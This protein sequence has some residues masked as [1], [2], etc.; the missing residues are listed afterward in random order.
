MEQRLSLVTLAAEDLAAARRFYEALGWIVA[1]SD[2]K[3]I[4]FFQL[5]GI[6]FSLYRR[7]AMAAELDCPEEV[8][9]PGGTALAYNVHEHDEVDAVLEAA[10]AAGG[11]IRP[12]VERVWGGYSGYFADADGHVWEVAWNPH[13]PI[14]EDGNV[15]AAFPQAS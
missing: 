2:D 1:F 8:L 14:D 13:W 15:K 7:A 12:A 6:V 4:V 11:S 10:A 3:D 9:G 5:N